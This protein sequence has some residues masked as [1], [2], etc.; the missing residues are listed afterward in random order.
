MEVITMCFSLLWLIELL[1]SIVVIAAV[2]AILY[3]VV[4]YLLNMLGVASGIVMQ[5]IKIIVAAIIIIAVLWI[6]YDLVSC[7]ALGPSPYRRLP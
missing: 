5:V 2:V 4:P 1:I 7:T 6:L 3:L